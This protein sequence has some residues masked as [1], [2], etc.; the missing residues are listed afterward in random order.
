MILAQAGALLDRAWVASHVDQIVIR[1][2][3][4]LG[5]TVAAVGVGTV[6][7]LPLG[8]FTHRY[9]RAAAPLRWLGGLLSLIPSLAL[10]A[11]LVPFT[12]PTS[13]TALL[14]LASYVVLIL[15][16]RIVAGLDAVGAEVKEAALGS[17]MG[18]GAVLRRVELPVAMP[19]I[20]SGIR[21]ATVT[22]IGLVTLTALI[23]RAGLGAFIL[24]GLEQAFPTAIFVGAAGSIALAAMTNVAI[25]GLRRFL[26]PWS[27]L[28][29]EASG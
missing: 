11:L 27:R 6:I 23:D 9:R 5:L 17:G 26:A 25:M 8:I 28:A 20:V 15:V 19:A 2:V 4:H 14:G 7:A 29:S 10:L 1:A 18:R 13:L 22:T 12:G 24:D 3:E 16:R 21:V